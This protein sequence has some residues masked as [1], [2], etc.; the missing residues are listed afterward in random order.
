M[1][2]DER[3]ALEMLHLNADKGRGWAM[4]DLGTFY[5]ANLGD[6]VKGD[7]YFLK[8][9]EAGFP[10]AFYAVGFGYERRGEFVKAV[11]CF[12][13]GCKIGS[14]TCAFNLGYCFW[15]GKGCIGNKIEGIELIKQ[16]VDVE[17]PEAMAFYSKLQIDREVESIGA[18][19]LELMKRAAE[20]GS[21]RAQ[22]Y[23]GSHSKDVSESFSYFKKAAVQGNAE[24]QYR[25]A[26]MYFYEPEVLK[27]EGV[28]AVK[29]G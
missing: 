21:P 9:C 2:S 3:Q 4:F 19:S 14:V 28:L 8:A 27:R 29:E 24:A 15:M 13:K 25:L 6:L 20:L 22:L 5:S 17:F 1:P 16:A 7:E 18:K 11:E 10:D 26:R 23:L 12:R